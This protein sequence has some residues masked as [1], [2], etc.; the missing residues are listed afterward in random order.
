MTTGIQLERVETDFGL[1]TVTQRKPGW[2]VL[3]NG[4]WGDF[5]VQTAPGGRLADESYA[6]MMNQLNAIYRMEG[7]RPIHDE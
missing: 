7:P 3:H 1:F 2:V 4:H 5:A 6:A